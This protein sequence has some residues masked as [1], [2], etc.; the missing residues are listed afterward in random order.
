LWWV[1]KGR[2]TL[3]TTEKSIINMIWL[4]PSVSDWP[5]IMIGPDGLLLIVPHLLAFSFR[6]CKKV[7]N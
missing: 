3:C 2:A 4:L 6:C 1:V 7:N 5:I